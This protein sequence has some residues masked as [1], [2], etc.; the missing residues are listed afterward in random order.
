MRSVSIRR[1]AVPPLLPHRRELLWAAAV[2]LVAGPS[3]AACSSA[4]AAGNGDVPQEVGSQPGWELVYRKPS[5]EPFT[6]LE[7]EEL[8]SVLRARFAT[9]G[10]W[11][12]LGVTAG[13]QGTLLVALPEVDSEQQARALR[14]R[15]ERVGQ[16]SFEAVASRT[17]PGWT[18]LE[19]ERARLE[20]WWKGQDEPSLEAFNALPREAGGPPASVR[21]RALRRAADQPTPDPRE[22]PF[23][24]PCAQMEFAYPDRDWVFGSKD[25][26]QVLRTTDD[27]GYPAIGFELKPERRKA[28]GDF[29]AAHVDQQLAIVLDGV[30]ISAPVIAAPLRGPSV[31]QGRF[32]E[33]EVD[34]MIAAL[35][36]GP[37]PVPLEFVELRPLAPR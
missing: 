10:R 26:G 29:T 37:L 3:A 5:G 20:S 16:F 2:V 24:L 18:L 13:A 34:A 7:V 21:W 31:I 28:F 11:A 1:E 23:V 22:L 35:R 33:A 25:M 9:D 36:S 32:E 30:V 4:S 17:T 15:L 12:K 14:P 6:S 19:D 27:I 8:G